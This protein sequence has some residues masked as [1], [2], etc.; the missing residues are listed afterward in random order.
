MPAAS[1]PAQDPERDRPSELPHSWRPLGTT[2]AG[3]MASTTVLAA[4]IAA[5]VLLDPEVKDRIN[6]IQ[7]ATMVLLLG[8]AAATLWAVMRCR[9]TATV[10]ALVVVNGYKRY[11]YAWAQVVEIRL[12]RGAPWASLDLADG[13]TRSV[14]ALQNADGSRALAGVRGIRSLI[15]SPPG[16]GGVGRR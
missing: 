8:L 4:M 14:V 2:I 3:V 6:W 12:P 11:E 9:I 16:P 13:T 7:R 5:W 1:D 15:Y 10:D